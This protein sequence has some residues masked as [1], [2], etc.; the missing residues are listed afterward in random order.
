MLYIFLMRVRKP[1]HFKSDSALILDKLPGYF[2]M[3]CLLFALYFMVNILIPFI[4]VVFI[5]AVLAIAFDPIHKRLLKLFNGWSRLAS[6]VSCLLIVLIILVPIAVFIVL[7]T[8]E[9]FSTYEIIQAKINSGVFDKY[10]QWKD[11]GYFYDL[12]NMISPFVD[13]NSIDLKQNIIE[14][15]KS[16]STFLISQT[17]SFLQSVSEIMLDLVVL[18]FC[19]F[20]FFK[21][22][23]ALVARIGQLSP[24]PSSYE[25]QLFYKIK[26]MVRA[27]VFGVFF[28]AV[29]QG[30]VGGVGFTIAGISNPV[31]WGTAMAFFSL[32]PVV[33]TAIIWVPAAIILFVLGD[34]YAAAFLFFWGIFVVGTVDNFARPYLIR[35]NTPTYPL[36]MF[37]VVLGGVVTMGL[38]GVVVGPLVLI[39]LMS[40]LHIYEFEYKNLLKK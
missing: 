27:V 14:I 2:L 25:D 16:L 22:G 4:T 23:N 34:Y 37:L 8:G 15:V 28:T 30:V 38:K 36:M 20:Y 11:G 17:A 29:L 24:L 40:F 5:G 3:V 21:D 6:A 13:M 35:G 32:F 39:V 19:L 9:A 10:L 12:K 26:D 18:M 31:F 1:F 7:L 33:G